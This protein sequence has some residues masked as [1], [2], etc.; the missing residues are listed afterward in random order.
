MLK[1]EMK[2]NNHFFFCKIKSIAIKRM[3]IK[4]N[5][6]RKLKENEIIKNI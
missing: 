2:K 1:N 3:K 4:S 6:K 5:K